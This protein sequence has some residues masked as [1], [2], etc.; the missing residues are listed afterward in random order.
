MVQI[1]NYR[2]Q[3]DFHFSLQMELQLAGACSNQLS[4]TL[5][6]KASSIFNTTTAKAQGMLLKVASGKTSPAAAVILGPTTS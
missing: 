4:T 5:L 2:F 1:K 6:T 3:Y